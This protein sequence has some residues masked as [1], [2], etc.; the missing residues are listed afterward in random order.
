MV[1]RMTSKKPWQREV[2]RV[3]AE[4]FTIRP[5]ARVAILGVGNELAG[6]DAAGSLV[7]RNLLQALPPSERLLVL[8]GGLAPES[9]VGKL[10]AQNSRCLGKLI[11]AP[12]AIQLLDVN[13]I[14]GTLPSTHTLSLN[15]LTHYLCQALTCAVYFL[16]IQPEALTFDTP[17]SPTAAEAV[18]AATRF[19]T[20]LVAEPRFDLGGLPAAMFQNN[21]LYT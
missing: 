13:R 12:G 9:F 18:A 10:E 1:K 4:L 2:S 21:I 14:P 17:L 6:D 15:V 3:F 16:G 11:E 20:Q 7:A 8:D 19:L 5:D